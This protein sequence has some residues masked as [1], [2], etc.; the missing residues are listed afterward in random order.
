[1]KATFLRLKACGFTIL[2]LLVAVAVLAVVVVIA[3]QVIGMSWKMVMS[4]SKKIDALTQARQALDRFGLDWNAR[5]TRD[6]VAIDLLSQAG[7]D[8]ISFV[9]QMPA[10]GGNRSMAVINYRV[11]GTDA[12]SDTYKLE[13]G[14][15]GF[16][17]SG[18][19]PS[20]SFPMTSLPVLQPTDRQSL[21]PGVFRMKIARLTKEDGTNAPVLINGST[22]QLTNVAAVVVAVGVIDEKSRK[23]LTGDQ[24]RQLAAALPDPPA[25]NPDALAT[26]QAAISDPDFANRAGIPQAIVPGVRVYQRYFYVTP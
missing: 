9:S 10:P 14:A 25:S 7:N 23:L 21:S 12:G 20:F 5:V 3:F 8:E 15:L 17:W 4:D 19:A 16:N 22:T 24:M 6:D 11:D 2:E 13:R 26:W 1:M 18:A